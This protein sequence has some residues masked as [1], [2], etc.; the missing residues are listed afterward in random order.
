M[1]G[2]IVQNLFRFILLVFV[3]VFILNQITLP[4]SINAYINPNIYILFILMLPIKINRLFLLLICFVCGFTIDIF[5][6]TAG[7]HAS[8]C[9]FIGL[10]RPGFI[11]LIMPR[12]GYENT[13]EMTLQGLG[14]RTFII[15]TGFLVLLHHLALFLIEAFN[16]LNFFDLLLRVIISALS[17][18]ILIIL[19]QLLTLRNR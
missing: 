19:S 6:S 8:A 1:I 12:D 2:T 11:N 7:M 14:F 10:A 15:Y 9:L 4:G 3:Q 5:S 18:L 16:F 13:V 17:T